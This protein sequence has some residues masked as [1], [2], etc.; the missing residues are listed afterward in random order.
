ME[1]DNVKATKLSVGLPFGLG[2]L[3]F[4]PDETQQHAAWELY[5]EL[6][7]RVAIHPLKPDEGFI[8]E[9]ITSLYKIVEAT[10]RILRDAGPT[11]AKGP[12]SF[13]P[14]AIE[15]IVKGIRPF[16]SKWHPLLYD[17]EHS[18]QVDVEAL[19]HERAWDRAPEFFSDLAELQK[20]M[21]I[22]SEAL[23]RISGVTLKE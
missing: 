16:L 17:F 23:A 1:I 20:Q 3:E 6:S 8:R 4:V 5:I 13:G 12:H 7:T 2:Q 15:V 9:A 18:R 19:E 10:R 21:Q 14:V 22:Y 11:V